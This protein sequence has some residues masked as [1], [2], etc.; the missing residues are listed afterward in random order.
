M[1][2]IGNS[3][4]S[5]LE[6]KKRPELRFVVIGWLKTAGLNCRNN[7]ESQ[8]HEDVEESRQI[9]LAVAADVKVDSLLWSS[10]YLVNPLSDEGDGALVNLAEYP[11]LRA[12]LDAHGEELKRRHVARACL[13]SCI[14][15]S[16]GFGLVFEGN[17]SS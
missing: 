17:L 8:K 4:W 2:K 3:P 12:Y 7:L 6:L 15:L 9:P 13:Q 1:P 5:D 16:T 14:A 11:G 10:H